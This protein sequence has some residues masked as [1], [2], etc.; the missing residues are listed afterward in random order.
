[1]HRKYLSI[2]FDSYFSYVAG[3]SWMKSEKGDV[4]TYALEKMNIK[5]YSQ[6]VMIG[7]REY[8]NERK[9]MDLHIGVL[10]DME[11]EKNLNSGIIGLYCIVETVSE[12]RK[13]CNQKCMKNFGRIAVN[14][15]FED[16]I[17]SSF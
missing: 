5:E 7:D 9:S 14:G 2:S 17:F 10:T 4:I 8:D 11:A 1:M 12:L 13:N 16:N 15:C 6:A 3:S